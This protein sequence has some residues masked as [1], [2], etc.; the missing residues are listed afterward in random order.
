MGFE[1]YSCERIELQA[2]NNNNKKIE[3]DKITKYQSYK[4]ILLTSLKPITCS[5]GKG[6]AFL[7]LRSQVRVSIDA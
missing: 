4:T 6:Q 2:K 5:N 7:K 3:I 1:P